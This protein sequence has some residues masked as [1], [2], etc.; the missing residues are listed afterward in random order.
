[1]TKVSLELMFDVSSDWAEHNQ[2]VLSWIRAAVFSVPSSFQVPLILERLWLC[3][4]VALALKLSLSFF[5]M[6][7]ILCVINPLF[8]PWDICWYSQVPS[9]LL[10]EA[11]CGLNFLLNY[12]LFPLFSQINLVLLF[13]RTT[14]F[15]VPASKYFAWYKIEMYWYENVKVMEKSTVLGFHSI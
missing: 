6:L 1:M 10:H 8:F 2:T 5:S 14:D 12:S 11:R 13:L 15:L 4:S 3:Y 9:A 7:D